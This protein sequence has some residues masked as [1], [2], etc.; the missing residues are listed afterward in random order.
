[1]Q[2]VANASRLTLVIA[3]LLLPAAATMASDYEAGHGALQVWD[4]RAQDQLPLPIKI[5][6]LTM[7]T[8]FSLGLAFVRKHLEA[9][10]VV[11]GVIL[12]I[13]CSR[14]LIPE[15]GIVKLSGLVALVH[16]IFWSPG[17]YMLL[18]HRPFLRDLGL[19]R[20]WAGAATAVI[21]VSFVFD[22]RDAAIYLHH[23]ANL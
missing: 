22:I 5:W 11:G 18:R 1:M 17:L 12:G 7:V 9:R 19:Y 8:V 16:L 20:F 4:S 14:V 10:F 2:T 6:L 13:L 15:L 21:I 3:A 23:I